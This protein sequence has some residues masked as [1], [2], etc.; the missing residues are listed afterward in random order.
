MASRQAQQHATV[1]AVPA[2]SQLGLSAA[3]TAQ[4]KVLHSARTLMYTLQRC[5]KH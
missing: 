4:L 3:N 1:R 5:S 2:L